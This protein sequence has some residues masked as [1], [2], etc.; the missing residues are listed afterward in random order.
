MKKI[1]SIVLVV[2]MLMSVC[3]VNAFALKDT[4][5]ISVQIFA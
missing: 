5:G 2:A 1:L 3:T 4:K